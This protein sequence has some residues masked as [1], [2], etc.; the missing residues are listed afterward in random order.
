MSFRIERPEYLAQ[1]R[2]RA[3]G[4]QARDLPASAREEETWLAKCF[5]TRSRR[6][7]LRTKRGHQRRRAAEL[8]CLVSLRHNIDSVMT[9]ATAI[10][11][12]VE[13]A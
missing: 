9:L 7:P 10:S 13:L 11:G 1:L 3:P 8:S 6:T 4:L 12:T 2:A 5:A